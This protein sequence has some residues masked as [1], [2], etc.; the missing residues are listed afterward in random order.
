MENL[1]VSFMV[2]DIIWNQ[3]ENVQ[4]NQCIQDALK[5]QWSIQTKW[6]LW[7]LHAKICFKS[8]CCNIYDPKLITVIEDFLFKV[9]KREYS[10]ANMD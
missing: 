7:K 6:R 9:F 8:V 10:H 2:D 5:F 1:A 4:P 3:P